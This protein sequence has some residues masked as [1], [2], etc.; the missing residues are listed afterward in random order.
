MSNFVYWLSAD[1]AP[2]FRTNAKNAPPQTRLPNRAKMTIV[3]TSAV[4]LPE[5]TISH[6]GT[7]VP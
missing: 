6:N 7:K 3:V 1:L 5:T 2:A 4:S